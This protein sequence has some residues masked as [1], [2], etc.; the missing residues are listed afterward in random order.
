MSG[1]RQH[2]LPAAV[3][4][5]FAPGPES[6]SARDRKI[7]VLRRNGTI[8]RQSAT[9]VAYQNNLYDADDML[10]AGGGRSG[11][12]MAVPLD[13]DGYWASSEERANPATDALL[14]NTRGPYPAESWIHLAQYIAS[15]FARSPDF[16]ADHNSRL[17][18]TPG[19]PLDKFLTKEN[20]NAV[21]ILENMRVSAAVARARWTI[22]LSP[23]HPLIMND[24]GATA[25][26]HIHND[27]YGYAVPLRPHL[28]VALERGP[29]DK[30]IVWVDNAWRIDIPTYTLDS[31]EARNLNEATWPQCRRE[32][33]AGHEPELR[34]LKQHTPAPPPDA[35]SPDAFSYARLLGL[36]PSLR[37][38]SE[39]LLQHLSAGI[40]PLVDPTRPPIL[41]I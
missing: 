9:T 2:F 24:R 3:I 13:I 33:Y 22:L 27:S 8:T 4:G 5:R 32:V 41:K 39:N 40:P 23:S 10:L 31:V 6:T 19:G 7:W 20:V 28:A 14:K 26:Y 34:R 12:L 17:G 38:D 18:H 36:S 35:I 37:R 30:P 29:W 11:K 16:P 25:L 21:R 15:I 1:P